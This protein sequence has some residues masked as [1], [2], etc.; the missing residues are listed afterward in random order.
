MNPI[1]ITIPRECIYRQFE[2]QPG[3]CPRCGS[4][5]QPSPQTYLVATRRAGR[6]ADSFF[7]GGDMGWFCTMCP[8]VVI[9]P[10]RVSAM[11]D[12]PLPGG[13]AGM[14]FAV[15]GIL[16]LGDIPPGQRHLPLSELETLPLVP[17]RW[18][19]GE[20]F[21]LPRRKARPSPADA[22]RKSARKSKR[23]RKR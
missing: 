14:E 17:F 18:G 6:I 12:S 13:G 15:V 21:A 2:N 16:N 7:I 19:P 3:P 4:P 5:L 10:D 1:D 8:T 9:N 20:A 11:M 22:Q 23:K